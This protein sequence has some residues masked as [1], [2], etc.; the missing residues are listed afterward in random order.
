MPRR[1]RLPRQIACCFFGQPAHCSGHRDQNLL[2]QLPAQRSELLGSRLINR[3]PGLPETQ[4]FS[5]RWFKSGVTSDFRMNHESNRIVNQRL[6]TMTAAALELSERVH[7]C[8][9]QLL[10]NRPLF[11]GLQGDIT[12]LAP[13]EHWGADTTHQALQQLVVE[14]LIKA[15]HPVLTTAANVFVIEFHPETRIDSGSANCRN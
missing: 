5:D 12:I 6:T 14:G 11:R 7:Q 9:C 4:L 2:A 3:L 10:S 1:P 13:E 15:F 8:R